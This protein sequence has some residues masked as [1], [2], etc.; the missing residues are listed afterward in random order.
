M[1]VVSLDPSIR[2]CDGCDKPQ[3]EDRELK[4][5]GRC[6]NTFYCGDKC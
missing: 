2:R 1:A 5:C 4:K 6:R 3:R